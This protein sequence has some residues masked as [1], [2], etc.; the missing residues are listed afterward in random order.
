[1]SFDLQVSNGDLVIGNNGDLAQ[2]TGSDK[3]AQS[4]LKIVLTPVG[5]N[6]VQ[7]WYGSLINKT[8]VGSILKTDIVLTMAQ[9]QLQSAIETLQKI[10]QLQIASGQAV[11]PDEQIAAVSSINITRSTTDPRVLV[12]LLS[13][14]NRAFGR[15]ST[16]FTVKP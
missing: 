5:G 16:S 10:Q 9:G 4:L 12:I 8:L 2:I 3:L 15:V 6:P 13:V 14:L 11:T 1:M 7:P